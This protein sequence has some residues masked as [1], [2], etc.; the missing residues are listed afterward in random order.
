MLKNEE[1][2]T[3]D[4]NI[5]WF[6]LAQHVRKAQSSNNFGKLQVY[7]ILLPNLLS[8]LEPGQKWRSLLLSVFKECTNRLF[9]QHI[10]L[11][12]IFCTYAF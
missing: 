6:Y 8:P 3:W 5:I 11:K 7:Y 12:N 2:E 10:V 1:V 4:I 9:E